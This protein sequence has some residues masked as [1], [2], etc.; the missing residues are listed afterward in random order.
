[1]KTTRQSKVLRHSRICAAEKLCHSFAEN[2]RAHDRLD[3]QHSK[4]DSRKPDEMTERQRIDQLLTILS[5][6]SYSIENQAPWLQAKSTAGATF[7]LLLI[8]DLVNR[9]EDL[10]QDASAEKQAAGAQLRRKIEGC[11]YSAVAI[12]ERAA[13]DEL[14]TECREQFMPDHCNPHTMTQEALAAA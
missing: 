10:I 3:E 13:N 7:Q 8:S 5:E 14:L 1:M 12:F 6:Q 2:R 4:L 11:L 9:F